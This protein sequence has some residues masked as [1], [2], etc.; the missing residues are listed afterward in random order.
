MNT[1]KEIIIAIVVAILMIAICLIIYLVN[2]NKNVSAPNVK[3]YKL[4]EVEG[5]ED[6][7]VYKECRI[8]TE[9]QLTLKKEFKR[10][11]KLADSKI[12]T[13]KSIMGSYKI[14]IDDTYIAFD[15]KEDKIFYNGQKNRLY[16]LAS[17]MYEIV[18]NTCE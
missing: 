18:I 5:S 11:T 2:T 14:I 10:A 1:K 13:G 15:N 3:V 7:H 9:D 16:N 4:Y 8:S 17:Q 6:E 12:V